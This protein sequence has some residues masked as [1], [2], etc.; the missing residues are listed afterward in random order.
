MP[1]HKYF[2]NKAMTKQ[3]TLDLAKRMR[4]AK[5]YKQPHLCKKL[6][7]RDAALVATLYTYGKRISETLALTK[8]DLYIMSDNLY[9][10]FQVK[11][12]KHFDKKKCPKC[13][14]V[15]KASSLF[16]SICAWPL[17]NEPAI[18]AKE[19][20]LERLKHKNLSYPLIPIILDWYEQVPADGFMFPPAIKEFNFMDIEA[21]MNFNKAMTPARAWQIIKKYEVD[22]FPHFFRH[23]LASNLSAIGF[24]EHHLMDW[25]DWDR[26]E[27][28]RK[29][30]KLA[31]GK[32]VDD[33]AQAPA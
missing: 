24:D 12:K 9:I 6:G 28:A 21:E 4:T 10:R 32:R 16:C 31:G 7:Q 22:L 27:T 19:D 14:K 1:R 11:K 17:K 23:S 3:Q 2:R 13:N 33:I 26:I 30:M 20:I 18:K 29:Y 5:E 8:D 15:T 25:F